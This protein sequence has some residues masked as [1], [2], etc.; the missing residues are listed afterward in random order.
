M[1]RLLSSDWQTGSPGEGLV[2]WGGSALRPASPSHGENSATELPPPTDRGKAGPTRARPFGMPVDC[3]R[4]RD[5]SRSSGRL[6]FA[7]ATPH[8]PI[9]L[10]SSPGHRPI[11]R[12]SAKPCDRGGSAP[13]LA[14][15]RRSSGAHG[16]LPDGVF[17][18]RFLQSV[19]QRGCENS[20]ALPICASEAARPANGPGQVRPIW[21]FTSSSF[22][23]DWVPEAIRSNRWKVAEVQALIPVKG[24]PS[25]VRALYSWPR[26]A[27]LRRSCS[28]SS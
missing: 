2:T 12:I 17:D 9:G 25:A 1:V 16:P 22:S 14:L 3:T 11:T 5:R 19:G 20:Q 26:L 7:G 10:H 21:R 24:F 18:V 28:P 6:R 13:F 23:L 15:C 27:G 4:R 8:H